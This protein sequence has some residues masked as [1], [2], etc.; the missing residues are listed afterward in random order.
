[1]RLS[2]MVCLA[3]AASLIG[4]CDSA[5][6]I[7]SPDLAS[8]QPNF[9]TLVD[10]TNEQDVPW[11]PV[12]EPNPCNGDEIVINGTSHFVF[13]TVLE[14]SGG[15]HLSSHVG[16]KGEGLGTSGK[17]YIITEQ[18]SYMEQNSI[19]TATVLQEQTVVVRGPT[20]LDSY[21]RHMV[22]KLTFTPTGMPMANFERAFVQCHGGD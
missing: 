1:M 6:N 12:P 18:F 14:S 8:T 7:L 21:T 19:P 13:H 22:F 3:A 20:P 10:Q 11:V 2:A 17:Q 15:L 16:S 4:G 9:V 5:P